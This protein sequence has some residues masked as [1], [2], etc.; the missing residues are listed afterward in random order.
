[1]LTTHLH[2]VPWQRMSAAIPLFLLRPFM[3]KTGI[4]F[5]FAFFW[6]ELP[7]CLLFHPGDAGSKFLRIVCI[8][9]AN[10]MASLPRSLQSCPFF[11]LAT[12]IKTCVFSSGYKNH[13]HS[14]TCCTTNP[15]QGLDLILLAWQLD[16]CFARQNAPWKC[17]LWVNITY[18]AFRRQ[19]Q[20]VGVK[21]QSTTT[22]T[23]THVYSSTSAYQETQYYL[24]GS[25]FLCF[26]PNFLTHLNHSNHFPEQSFNSTGN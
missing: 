20:P 9:V 4:S 26:P 10:Y 7:W 21:D 6:N 8:C 19:W 22:N 14:L 5:F 2:L 12:N 25:S 3:A 17:R 18:S 23:W 15:G 11:F 24:H 16:G 13:S 1:M